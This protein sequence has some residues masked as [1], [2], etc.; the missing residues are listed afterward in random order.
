MAFFFSTSLRWSHL[1]R[2]SNPCGTQPARLSHRQFGQRGCRQPP[3]CDGKPCQTRR[4]LFHK[5]TSAAKR[6]GGGVSRRRNHHSFSLT[7]TA[8]GLPFPCTVGQRS[9][10]SVGTLQLRED[11]LDDGPCPLPVLSPALQSFSS[12]Q[13]LGETPEHVLCLLENLAS[14]LFEVTVQF[15]C[16]SSPTSGKPAGHAN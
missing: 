13:G 9:P 15:I 4:L 2:V 7:P 3:P 11:Q 1:L 10:G 14:S 16:L 12:V 6:E 8:P 5:G